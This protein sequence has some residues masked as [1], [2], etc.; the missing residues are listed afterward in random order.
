VRLWLEQQPQILEILGVQ[1]VSGPVEPVLVKNRPGHVAQV[2]KPALHQFGRLAHDLGAV[3]LGV[4]S[5]S[6]VQQTAQGVVHLL[7]QGR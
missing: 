5:V 2:A 1:G 7:R 6:G 4:D 3:G